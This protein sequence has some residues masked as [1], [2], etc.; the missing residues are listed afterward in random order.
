MNISVCKLPAEEYSGLNIACT[1]NGCFL[2]Y[3]IIERG[4]LV[5][6]LSGKVR[7]LRRQLQVV[8]L[9]EFF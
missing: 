3:I 4:G 2:V 9:E 5:R 1:F 6:L 8:N 7:Q